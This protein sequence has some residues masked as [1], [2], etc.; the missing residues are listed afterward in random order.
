MATLNERIFAAARLLKNSGFDD[1]IPVL[2]RGQARTIRETRVP[3][4]RGVHVR[5]LGGRVKAF[6]D[7]ARVKELAEA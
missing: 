5:L 6:L 4:K 1:V 7:E 3:R 2:M